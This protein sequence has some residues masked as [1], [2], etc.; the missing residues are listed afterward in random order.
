[1]MLEYLGEKKAAELI[2]KA[3]SKALSSGKI[4]DLAAGKMGMGTSE[5]GDYVASLI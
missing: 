4:T 5:V 1:M 2:D 3:V